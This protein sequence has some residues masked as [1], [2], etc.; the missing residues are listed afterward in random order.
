MFFIVI[1]FALFCGCI[2]NDVVETNDGA[3]SQSSRENVLFSMHRLSM[4]DSLFLGDT[5]LE[6]LDVSVHG[7]STL[8]RIDGMERLVTCYDAPLFVGD[9]HAVLVRPTAERCIDTP[10]ILLH[11]YFVS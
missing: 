2:G 4:G 11:A 9:G 5:F 8:L 10:S 7:T 1:V 6:C 3:P